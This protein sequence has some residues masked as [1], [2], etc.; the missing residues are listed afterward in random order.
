MQLWI[1]IIKITETFSI[2]NFNILYN[3]I[4]ERNED[5]KNTSIFVFHANVNA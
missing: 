5:I 4:I 3:I 2:Y 1:P